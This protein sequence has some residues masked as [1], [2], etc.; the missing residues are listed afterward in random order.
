MKP[1]TAVRTSYN[2]LGGLNISRLTRR[3][4]EFDQSSD[5]EK[6]DA[7]ND[8]ATDKGHRSRNLGSWPSTWVSGF[9]MLDDLRHN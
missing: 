2:S 9:D 5:T 7:E 1:E 4:N 8:K 3:W 6:T